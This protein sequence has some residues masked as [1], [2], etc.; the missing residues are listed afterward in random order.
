MVTLRQLAKAAS[1]G[2]HQVGRNARYRI[3]VPAGYIE[4]RLRF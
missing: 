4:R 3:I 1:L 2:N